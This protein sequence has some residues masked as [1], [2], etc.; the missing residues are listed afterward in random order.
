VVTYVDGVP[1]GFDA[2][3]DDED[4]EEESSPGETAQAN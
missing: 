4:T 2:Q 3:G 1:Q